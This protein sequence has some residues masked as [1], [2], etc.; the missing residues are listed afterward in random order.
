M[1]AQ[2]NNDTPNRHIQFD[3]NG[4][5]IENGPLDPTDGDGNDDDGDGVETVLIG[6][7]SKRRG[8]TDH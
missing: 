1:V 3:E 5:A 4:E 7:K 2:P 6:S 8:F